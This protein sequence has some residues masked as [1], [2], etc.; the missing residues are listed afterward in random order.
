MS[1]IDRSAENIYFLIILLKKFCN[2]KYQIN[3]TD[4]RVPIYKKLAIVG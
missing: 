3:I 2:S 1:E 4:N